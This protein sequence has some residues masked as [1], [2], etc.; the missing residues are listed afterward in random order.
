M[1]NKDNPHGFVPVG[2]ILSSQEYVKGT[3]AAIYPGDMVKL[4]T[5]AAA[6]QG[7]VVVAD[8]ANTQLV[9]VA[10]GYAAA[11]K[12]TVL[13]ADNPDQKYYVQVATTTI[14]GGQN[15]DILATAG[16]T[17]YFKSLHEIKYTGLTMATAQIRVLD[18]HPNDA[19]SNNS[20]HLVVINEHAYAKKLTGA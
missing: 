16:S 1:A 19:A 4:T 9:G 6:A 20:R 2:P 17:T 18:R 8:A 7:T 10:L 14:P 5:V 13:V 3:N 15:V 12:T 11:T